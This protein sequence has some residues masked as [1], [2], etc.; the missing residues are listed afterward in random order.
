MDEATH[1]AMAADV[2]LLRVTAH[3]DSIDLDPSV[4]QIAITRAYHQP[5]GPL[6]VGNKPS[7]FVLQRDGDVRKLVDQA[8]GLAYQNANHKE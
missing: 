6:L 8:H 3:S 2:P 1:A 7:M 5:A 4:Q